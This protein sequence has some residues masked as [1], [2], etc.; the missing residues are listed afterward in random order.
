[1]KA[2]FRYFLFIAVFLLLGMAHFSAPSPQPQC[3]AWMKQFLRHFR[4]L[5]GFQCRFTHSLRS[6]TLGIAETE[7]GTLIMDQ[8]GRSLWRYE[9]PKGKLAA[10]DSETATVI[11]PEDKV[12][13]RHKPTPEEL[14][15]WP[16]GAFRGEW[17]CLE[18]KIQSKNRGWLLLQ[19]PGGAPVEVVLDLSTWWI[20]SVHFTDGAGNS[21]TYTFG[22]YGSVE[23]PLPTEAF[24]PA[25]PN[26]FSLM[27]GEV[28]GS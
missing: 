18:A 2:P 27:E 14:H 10:W 12:V 25:V 13:W 19:P 4:S 3:D 24:R 1:M 16:I 20:I 8:E 6:P 9:N 23:N 28:V 17:P 7:N 22:E 5:P 11:L 15:L 21:I 26:G